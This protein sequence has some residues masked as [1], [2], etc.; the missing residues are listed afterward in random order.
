MPERVKQV[1]LFLKRYR[2]PKNVVDFTPNPSRKHSRG[3][4]GKASV[5]ISD[6]MLMKA[7]N[8]EREKLRVAQSDQKHKRQAGFHV[9]DKLKGKVHDM[10]A[11]SPAKQAARLKT[12]REQDLYFDSTMKAAIAS[13]SRSIIKQQQHELHALPRG[14]KVNSAAAK[15]GMGKIAGG[16]PKT[17]SSSVARDV[18][19]LKSIANYKRT[20]VVDFGP[21]ALVD[22]E[23]I[24]LEK[25][26]HALNNNK[27]FRKM[28]GVLRQREVVVERS[29]KAP[30]SPRPT[31]KPGMHKRNVPKLSGAPKPTSTAAIERIIRENVEIDVSGF[32]RE[33]LSDELDILERIQSERAAREK[34]VIKK[35][36]SNSEGYEGHVETSTVIPSLDSKVA[37]TDCKALNRRAYNQRRAA[38]RSEKTS[39]DERIVKAKQSQVKAMLKSGVNALS[40]SIRNAQDEEKAENDAGA[41]KALQEAEAE[42]ARIA[43]Q[44]LREFR[45]SCPPLFYFLYTPS[46]AR[47]QRVFP[48]IQELLGMPAIPFIDNV[49]Q[50]V[51]DYE[52]L[53]PS[54]FGATIARCDLLGVEEA[55][56]GRTPQMKK[57]VKLPLGAYYTVNFSVHLSYHSVEGKA[58]AWRKDVKFSLES[59]LMARQ[60]R[61]GDSGEFI[62]T[63]ERVQSFRAGMLDTSE[64]SY[65]LDTTSYLADCVFTAL[66]LVESADKGVEDRQSSYKRILGSLAKS[67][68][69]AARTYLKGYLVNY[70]DV[71]LC[72]ASGKP[73]TDESMSIPAVATVTEKYEKPVTLKEEFSHAALAPVSVDGLLPSFPDP[74]NKQNRVLGYYKR[75]M[76]NCPKPTQ[77]MQTLLR[78]SAEVLASM[79]RPEA[80]S[81]AEIIADCEEHCKKKGYSLD[82]ADEYMH[83]A[84]DAL[85]GDMPSRPINRMFNK[86]ELYD[87]AN[88]KTPRN[89][90]CPDFYTRGYTHALF[91]DAQKN[92]FSCTHQY[93]VKGLTKEGIAG[94]KNRFKGRNNLLYSDFKSMERNVTQLVRKDVEKPVMI[95]SSPPKRHSQI[96]AMYGFYEEPIQVFLGPEIVTTSSMRGSGEDLTSAGNYSFNFSCCLALFSALNH[97]SPKD[98]IFVFDAIF[99]GDDALIALTDEFP[100]AEMTRVCKELGVML[101]FEVSHDI[102][103]AEFCGGKQVFDGETNREV[104]NP[105]S[106]L[107]KVFT[108]FKPVLDSVKRDWEYFMAK[109]AS[110]YSDYFY[111][112]IVA[113]VMKALLEKYSKVDFKRWLPKVRSWNAFE[114]PLYAGAYN[115][116]MRV[117]DA[118]ARL[119]GICVG[120]QMRAE[121]SLVSQIK[122]GFSRLSCPSLSRLWKNHVTIPC[123][124]VFRNIDR[125]E[126]AKRISEDV[127]LYGGKAF[128]RIRRGFDV[129]SGWITAT[130]GKAPSVARRLR[131]I[132]LSTAIV[133]SPVAVCAALF[134]FLG[135]HP[136]L[137]GLFAFT[138]VVLVLGSMLL[139]VRT[140]MRIVAGTYFLFFFLWLGSIFVLSYFCGLPFWALLRNE[141]G[142]DPGLGKYEGDD[143]D[144]NDG[145]TEREWRPRQDVP[146]EHPD[147]VRF[148]LKG[149]RY[150]ES[151]PLKFSKTAVRRMLATLGRAA[152]TGATDP[153][154]P[155][156]AFLG[157]APVP[158]VRETGT[159]GARV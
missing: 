19:L 4:R 107:S 136:V 139:G 12:R 62:S 13:G 74:L 63:L 100:E 158:P 135:I 132:M 103:S 27:R 78:E 65:N 57:M 26:N 133:S 142:M 110:I 44:F 99:E 159:L 116:K 115:I 33:N 114:S 84:Y 16:L 118:V 143:D 112:P 21:Y 15:R 111:L 32:S 87:A 14:R 144:E 153:R 156:S 131:S 96:Q 43:A 109:V 36:F 105:L 3:K 30:V 73:S 29:V 157:S 49:P 149:E 95:A 134:H 2:K 31:G 79:V 150:M 25:G 53:V 117:R 138:V 102:E 85:K 92:L 51:L 48:Y 97:M 45:L 58:L 68:P 52:S 129:V 76:V 1:P 46:G 128:S 86:S 104:K 124:N 155:R 71:P 130:V 152:A 38:R 94:K 91:Y 81:D 54:F 7:L 113:P 151:Q 61:L 147:H 141:S 120:D 98:Y 88:K 60:R 35:T 140:A 66:L 69:L 42:K 24:I 6:E 34:G 72:E 108:L 119:Y 70:L 56:D 20:G 148:N 59:L 67:F 125:R 122:A 50:V 80:H 39:K 40:T 47:V 121:Q 17:A 106:M 18:L 9:K 77:V 90:I 101:K 126:Q 127:R 10:K 137:V 41:E 123:M 93:N 5:F 37:A 23:A 82:D 64:R 22:L 145:C 75:L 146:N 28:I 11:V 154:D 55:E 89:I 8:R 83:G